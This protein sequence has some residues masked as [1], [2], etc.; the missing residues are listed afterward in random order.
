MCR[1]SSYDQ[2]CTGANNVNISRL[3]TLQLLSVW[4]HVDTSMKKMSTRCTCWSMHQLHSAGCKQTAD[5]SMPFLARP[6]YPIALQFHLVMSSFVSTYNG[7]RSIL[8][9][10]PAR[11]CKSMP[12]LA[13]KVMTSFG[14][15]KDRSMMVRD[16]MPP[17]ACTCGAKQVTDGVTLS[18]QC[19]DSW[20]HF[21]CFFASENAMVALLCRQYQCER[22]PIK[23]KLTNPCQHLP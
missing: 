1:K 4:L 21:G 2:A 22:L 18:P 11:P 23:S 7:A 8:T 17:P 5:M 10:A 15:L 9:H 19:D 3:W 6:T 16:L 12:Q 20:Q 14:V 13:V